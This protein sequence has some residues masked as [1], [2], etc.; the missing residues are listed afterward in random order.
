MKAKNIILFIFLFVAVIELLSK[1]FGWDSIG[2]VNITVKPLLMPS[3][4]AYFFFSVE[5]KNKLAFMVIIAL[6][7]SWIGDIMLLFQELKPIYFMLGL[8]SFLLAHITY[9]VVFNRSSQSFKPK[10]FTYSTGFLLAL[11]GILLLLLMW[12]GLG[13][14]K[15]PVIIYTIIIMTMGITALFRRANGASLVLIGA[16]LFIASDSL[17]ALN[18]FYQAFAAAGFWVMLT[19]IL[20]QYLIVSGM[21]SYFSSPAYKE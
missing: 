19:Y 1:I 18:K 9:I 13:D 10:I 2:T 17:L 21:I 4:A 3:L 11:Y 5:Q 15:I 6:L 14:M 8:V 20:A 16:M 7:F 12:A